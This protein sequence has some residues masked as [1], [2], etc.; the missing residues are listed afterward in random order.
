[1]TS[2]YKH[3]VLESLLKNNE[4]AHELFMRLLEDSE[5]GKIYYSWRDLHDKKMTRKRVRQDLY[6]L[7]YE[8]LLDFKED[9]DGFDVRLVE[10]K[11]D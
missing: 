11:D 7:S 5:E 4:R 8:N 3:F 6:E 1:M 2:L 10:E 9:S